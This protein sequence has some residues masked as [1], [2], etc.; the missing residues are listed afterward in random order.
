MA[1]SSLYKHQHSLIL[2]RDLEFLVGQ[3]FER[4]S[5]QY[6]FIVKPELF[7][8][9]KVFDQSI[10]ILNNN[11]LFCLMEKNNIVIADGLSETSSF[12]KH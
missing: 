4:L 12:P 8:T 11:L 9:L 1:R 7:E 6:S 5:R 10:L 2:E 3:I